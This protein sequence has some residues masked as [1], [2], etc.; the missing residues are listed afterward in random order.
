M[1]VNFA[2]GVVKVWGKGV[3]HRVLF[4]CVILFSYQCDLFWY[5]PII[6]IANHSMALRV[7]TGV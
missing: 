1:F 3:G 7:E 4:V 5:G 6:F 2:Y